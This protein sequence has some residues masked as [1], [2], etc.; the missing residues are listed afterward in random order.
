MG[1]GMMGEEEIEA[2]AQRV[3]ENQDEARRLY[4]QLYSVKLRDFYLRTAKIKERETS[5]DD[6][7]KLAEKR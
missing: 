1:Q 2:T 3:L 4:E 5:Y 6:F 7:V